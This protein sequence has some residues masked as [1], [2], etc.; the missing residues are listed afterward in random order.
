MNAIGSFETSVNTNVTSQKSV[1]LDST[2]VET[3]SLPEL[4]FL[5]GGELIALLRGYLLVRAR[6]VT[7]AV[8]QR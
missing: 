2:A 7:S 1:M 8:Q 3:S 4:L 5:K 6:S